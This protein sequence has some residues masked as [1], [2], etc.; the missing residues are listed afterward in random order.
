MFKH[1]IN[2]HSFP[3][4]E[5]LPP[6]N[7]KISIKR[8]STGCRDLH[9]VW[10]D[11]LFLVIL[12]M[13]T[14]HICSISLAYMWQIPHIFAHFLY[15]N[16]AHIT[17]KTLATNWYAYITHLKANHRLHRIRSVQ[18]VQAIGAN[19]SSLLPATKET[20]RYR[21]TARTRRHTSVSK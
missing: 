11:I 12:Y 5:N 13:Y 14:L 17:R 7:P 15:P 20:L 2:F 1:T 10:R 19:R 18:T 8:I 3:M 9:S 6:S 21:L 4:L 16:K